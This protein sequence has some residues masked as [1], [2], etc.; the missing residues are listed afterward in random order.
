[1]S[2]I[3]SCL[4]RWRRLRRYKTPRKTSRRVRF[5]ST[6]V[7]QQIS[8]VRNLLTARNRHPLQRRINRVPAPIYRLRSSK[9][10][11]TVGRVTIRR[12]RRNNSLSSRYPSTTKASSSDLQTLRRSQS[13]SP[14]KLKNFRKLFSLSTVSSIVKNGQ[15]IKHT[16]PCITQ[17]QTKL[18]GNEH[19]TENSGRV[20]GTDVP[21][22]GGLA[23]KRRYQVT[24]K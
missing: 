8:R 12:P 7:R 16:K 3:S 19:R 21:L 14:Q 18:L 15:I 20:G 9:R 5:Q 13:N 10:V 6:S 2:C 4:R 24:A 23:P 17:Q 11:F 1:M 22:L